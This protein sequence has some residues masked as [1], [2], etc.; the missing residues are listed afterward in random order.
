MVKAFEG[1]K[2]SSWAKLGVYA[3]GLSAVYYSTLVRLVGHDWQ[4]EDFNY[5]YLIPV[6]VLYFIWEKRGRLVSLASRVSWSGIVLVCLGL[7]LFWIGD[8]AGEFFTLYISFWL[9]IVGLVW[10]HFG[11][12]KLKTIWF[13]M[14]MILGMFPL[15]NILNV[16]LTLGLKLISS[17]L[18]VA[19]L[20]LYGM[21]AYREGNVIDLGF[22]QLQAD[23]R[24]Q[25]TSVRDAPFGAEPD[26]CLLVQ[27]AYLEETLSDRLLHPHRDFRQ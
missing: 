19:M 26:P 3:L 1:V 15:P 6:I 7:V 12:E 11:W 21:S 4:E 9:V 17:Q 2:P 20:Q 18:G 16:R 8:L 14:L 13:S 22:T 23:R 25:R 5:C 10:L 27:V 24:M